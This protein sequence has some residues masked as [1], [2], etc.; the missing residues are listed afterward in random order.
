MS[1]LPPSLPCNPL[2]WTCPPPLPVDDF[3][4]LRRRLV[5]DHFK[6]DPQVGDVETLARYPLVLPAA[7][8]RGLAALAEA[9]AAESEAA[10]RELLSRPD[11]PRRLGLPRRIRRVLA[12]GS[13]PPTPA[14]ARVIRFDFHPTPDGW[15]ISEANSDV[16]GGYA[17]SS[18]F[19]AL[20]AEHWPGLR[21]IGDPVG[22][23][24]D[25]LSVRGTGRVGL[26]AAPGYMEDQQVVACLA[27]AFFRRGWKTAQGHPGQVEWRDG[28]AYLR[29][30]AAYLPLDLVVRFFQGEW[31]GRWRDVVRWRPYFRGGRTA[32]C[33]PGTALLTESKRFPLVWDE[34]KTPLPTWRT[35]LPETRDPR[36]VNWHRDPAWLLKAAFG[37]NG[38]EVIDRRSAG[39]KSWRSAKWSARLRPGQWVAQ[40]R[41]TTL[42]VQTPDGLMYPC[43]GVY[44]VDGRAA[45]IY[46]RIAP[47]P[48]IDYAA[49]DI[50]V[51]Q[52]VRLGS[53]D[54][55]GIS[56][57]PR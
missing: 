24:V 48:F 45:G 30:A 43:L 31:L 18:H 44:T 56:D 11:L 54:L 22:A 34:L 32:V 21:P 47:K 55:P 46:G 41:F 42:P 39:R 8:V 28:Q 37:N 9:L 13:A 3:A 2:Q 17:E 5:L 14:A 26:L 16:P 35:L 1:A 36:R 7:T 50:A 19:A 53:P 20:M 15:R 33:N 23:L 10:E 12:E 38:D 6:W 29:S 57:D 52:A 49:V 4:R 51:L 27:H 40:R 25:A